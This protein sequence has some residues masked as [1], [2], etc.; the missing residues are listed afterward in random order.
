[1]SICYKYNTVWAS[2][3]HN[4]IVALNLYYIDTCIKVVFAF[5]GPNEKA[6]LVNVQQCMIF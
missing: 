3:T 2:K 5:K 1:M 4:E 6:I